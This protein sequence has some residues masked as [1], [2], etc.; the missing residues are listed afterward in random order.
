MI[1]AS[2]DYSGEAIITPPRALFG[3]KQEL[4]DPAIET[5]SREIYAAVPGRLRKSGRQ[6]ESGR[7]I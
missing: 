3:E 5:F 4:C 2:F 1:A 6:T 7:F